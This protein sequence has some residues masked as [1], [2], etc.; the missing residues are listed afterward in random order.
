MLDQHRGKAGLVFASIAAGDELRVARRICKVHLLA[1]RVFHGIDP[2]EIIQ[3]THAPDQGGLV[4]GRGAQDLMRGTGRRIA[5]NVR[6]DKRIATL[7]FGDACL[8]GVKVD[9]LGPGQLG[10]A[11]RGDQ[12]EGD[13]ETGAHR[14]GL[15]GMAEPEQKPDQRQGQGGGNLPRHVR[16]HGFGAVP[17]GRSER[18]KMSDENCTSE[19]CRDDLRHGF[20]PGFG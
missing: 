16:R 11:G 7:Q 5:G 19:A 15:S 1:G 3:P 6:E 14:Q 8:D 10:Q 20:P 18:L 4:F 13:G 12:A 9:P 17:R 2:G